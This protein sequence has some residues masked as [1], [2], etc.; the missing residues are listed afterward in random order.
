ML[1]KC[2]FPNETFSNFNNLF[3][4]NAYYNTS[5]LTIQEFKVIIWLFLCKIYNVDNFFFFI[6]ENLIQNSF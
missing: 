4:C 5:D 2:D 6:F 1:S 3:Y